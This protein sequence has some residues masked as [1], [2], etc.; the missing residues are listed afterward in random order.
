MSKLG[1]V[2]NKEVYCKFKR[3]VDGVGGYGQCLNRKILHGGT[4]LQPWPNAFGMRKYFSGNYVIPFPKSS[5]DQTKKKV[6][7][8]NWRVFLPEFKWKQK[9]KSFSP[10]FGTIF[11]R[12]LWNLF[13]LTGPYSSGQ[14]TLQSQWEDAKSRWGD[15][16][17]RW[18]DASP[19]QFKYW[20]SGSGGSAPSRWMSFRNFLKKKLF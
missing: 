8:E 1:D 9:K 14:P 2:L 18:G 19:L 3:I 7:T 12:I 13:V 17:S 20:L 4:L 15:A 10:Q 6:F 16:N 5:G 11:G